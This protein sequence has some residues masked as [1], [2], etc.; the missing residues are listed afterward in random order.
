MTKNTLLKVVGYLLG[1]LA[2]YYVFIQLRKSGVSWHKVSSLVQGSDIILLLFCILLYVAVMFIGAV[3]WASFVNLI[4]S[5]LNGENLGELILV[6][7]KSNIGKY[8]PGNFMQF[9]GRNV[10]GSKLGYTHSNLILGTLYEIIFSILIGGLIVVLLVVPGF[11]VIN[12][13]HIEFFSNNQFKYVFVLLVLMLFVALAFKERILHLVDKY[14]LLLSNNVILIKVVSGFVLAYLIMGLCNL[15]IFYV[16][17]SKVENND[18]LNFLVIYL[19]SW[20]LGFI[21]PGPPGGFGIREAIYIS[22]LSLSYDLATIT[23]TALFLRVINIIGDIFYLLISITII[24]TNA[25]Q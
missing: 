6:H 19:I 4:S 12:F 2:F 8:L 10:L 20:I 1:G 21:I 25:D 17:N 14:K 11:T 16:L 23:L 18:Y 15:I 3:I 5:K 13:S 7:A 24:K 9:V 22:F